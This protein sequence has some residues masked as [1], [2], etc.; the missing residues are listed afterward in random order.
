MSE[1]LRT[2]RIATL[3]VVAGLA[4]A[5][6]VKQAESAN[7]KPDAWTLYVNDGYHP[8]AQVTNYGHDT[9]PLGRFLLSGQRLRFCEGIKLVQVDTNVGRDGKPKAQ[10]ERIFMRTLACQDGQITHDDFPK[11]EEGSGTTPVYWPDGYT[12]YEFVAR[13]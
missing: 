11:T 6:F 4:T 5:A 12:A 8:E 13:K 3:A 10:K 2:S 7:P 1:V 9:L